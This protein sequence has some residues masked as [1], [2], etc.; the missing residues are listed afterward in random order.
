ME[1]NLNTS[2]LFNDDDPTMRKLVLIL[3][4]SFKYAYRD[5]FNAAVI[6]EG[7]HCNPDTAWQDFKARVN[8]DSQLRKAA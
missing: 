7:R 3:E 1:H 6:T 8:A 4:E 2:D 5:G